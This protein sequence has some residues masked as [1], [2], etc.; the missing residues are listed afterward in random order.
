MRLT[1]WL[2]VPET[3]QGSELPVEKACQSSINQSPLIK[4]SQ[5]INEGSDVCCEKVYATH[6]DSKGAYIRGQMSR[7]VCA[8]MF[9]V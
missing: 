1:G 5:R 2:R 6:S 9:N 8:N 4:V 7:D 3:K